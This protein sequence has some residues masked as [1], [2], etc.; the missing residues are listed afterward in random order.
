MKLV[1]AAYMRAGSDKK[2][3]T[4]AATR[5]FS[6]DSLFK[7]AGSI[8]GGRSAMPQPDG[9]C[10]CRTNWAK[11]AAV[12]EHTCG[13]VGA[14]RAAK[15]VASAMEW[16]ATTQ[17]HGQASTGSWHEGT[18]REVRLSE[19]Q[20]VDAAVCGGAARLSPLDSGERLPPLLTVPPGPLPALSRLDEHHCFP[21]LS[22]G[23]R[24]R[25]LGASTWSSAGPPANSE[26]YATRSAPPSTYSSTCSLRRKWAYSSAS[27]V[28]HQRSHNSKSESP[29]ASRVRPSRGGLQSFNI[30]TTHTPGSGQQ[31]E[32]RTRAEPNRAKYR[33]T[34]PKR[35]A[36]TAAWATG[37]G[38]GG[39]TPGRARGGGMGGGI[40]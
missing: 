21:P 38:S 25:S 3:A 2:L 29:N 14:P 26:S 5:N 23:L 33:G 7:S 27:I 20:A 36:A 31:T 19:A 10:D 11:R 37:A 15:V 17:G 35:L 34:Q 16:V 40:N 12:Q 8:A 4:Q 18:H 9:T 22:P 39:H 24:L 13:W 28:S 1:S 32:P 30:K 6:L